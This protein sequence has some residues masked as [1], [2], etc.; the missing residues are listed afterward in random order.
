MTSY[1]ISGPVSKSGRSIKAD[2]AN[3]LQSNSELVSSTDIHL[4]DEHETLGELVSASLQRS[5]RNAVN[6]N[7][8]FGSPV[9]SLHLRFE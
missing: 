8:Q 9:M 3:R 1:D 4:R 2:S 6:L 7:L 5:S